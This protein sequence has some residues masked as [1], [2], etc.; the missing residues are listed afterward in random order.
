MW[1]Q[2]KWSSKNSSLLEYNYWI[3]SINL[4]LSDFKPFINIVGDGTQRVCH[5]VSL[6]WSC[7]RWMFCSL[8]EY[9]AEQKCASYVVYNQWYNWFYL[10]RVTSYSENNLHNDYQ[11]YTII[12]NNIGAGF[13]NT[14]RNLKTFQT[15]H[16]MS[17]VFRIWTLFIFFFC[18]IAGKWSWHV[19][20]FV[21]KFHCPGMIS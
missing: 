13:F 11:Y 7:V 9:Y 10:L 1:I 12:V 16:H 21:W 8:R 14:G 15:K 17:R 20:M 18:N 5:P 4:Y 2:L 19:K 6:N 3:P